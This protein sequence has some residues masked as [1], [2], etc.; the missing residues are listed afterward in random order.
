MSTQSSDVVVVGGGIVGCLSAYNLARR[1]MKVTVLE[2]DSVGSHASGFAFGGLDPLTGI[3]LPDPL[4]EFSLFSYGRHRSLARELHEATGIDPQF[5]VRERL[6]LAFDDDGVRAAQRDLEWMKDVRGFDVSWLETREA[7]AL[8]PQIS[9]EC[10]GALREQG[11]GAVEPYRL[12][13]AAVRA[14]ERFGVN[15]S[16]R[17]VTG[18]AS[19]GRRCTGVDLESE[20]IGAG[21]VVLAMGP[22]TQ[23]AS[24]W[25]G[26]ELPVEPL[27]GEIL[28]LRSDS[29]ALGMAV[30]YGGSYAAT[31]S[32]GLIWA[33]TTEEHAGFNESNTLAA[34]NSIMEDFLKMFPGLWRA[35]LVHHT[36]CLRPVTPDGLPIVSKVPGWENLYVATGG[37]RKG[38]LWSTGM[39]HVLADLITFGE[40]DVAGAESLDLARFS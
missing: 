5:E 21:A 34:R 32:D 17:R 40:T 23:E 15:K 6:N 3:G 18:L 19:E 24:G 20:S 4:L 37:G 12:L 27:K 1:G 14:G 22:W 39:A 10:L 28:R 31:K 11:T 2:T 9:R 29:E 13:L 33:G 7:I 36:A 30:N 25:C 16:Y 8:V 35:E 26:V 38:I